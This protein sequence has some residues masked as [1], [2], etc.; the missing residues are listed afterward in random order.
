MDLSWYKDRL[1]KA[2]DYM[3]KEFAGMQVGRATK[4]LVENINAKAAYGDMAIGQLANITLPDAQ[5]I[6][7]EPWDKSVLAAI[8]KGIYDA[9]SGLT[10]RNEGSYIMISIPPLTSERRQDIVK[11]IKTSGEDV[12]ARMRQIRQDEQKKIKA[13]LD[14]GEISEDE[15]KG[16][17]NK[18]TDIIKEYNAKIDLLVKNKSDEI[19]KI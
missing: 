14:A 10:P 19:M 15:K 9:N 1:Q 13:A 18:V 5:S 17:D 16:N 11:S 2:V 3:N 6:K 8:E 4:W 12:K 7:I